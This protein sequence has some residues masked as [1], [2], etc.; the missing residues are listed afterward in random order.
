[1]TIRMSVGVILLVDVRSV[2]LV[3]MD[4]FSEDDT[5]YIGG[6]CFH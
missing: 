5:G 3:G 1:M 2:G 4:G 6:S